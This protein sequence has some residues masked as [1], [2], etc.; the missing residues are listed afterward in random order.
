MILSES[1]NREKYIILNSN[2]V[3][4]TYA[5]QSVL[6]LG[7]RIGNKAHGSCGQGRSS[8]DAGT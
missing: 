4:S 3:L 7:N 8:V 1:L 5:C 6:I 2:Y